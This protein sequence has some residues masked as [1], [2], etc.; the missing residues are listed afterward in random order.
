MP[1]RSKRKTSAPEH[2]FG[3]IEKQIKSVK[4]VVVGTNVVLYGRSATGKTTLACTWPKPLLLIDINETGT[5]SVQDVEGVS[6]M[7]CRTWEELDQTYWYLRKKGIKKFK[8]VVVDTMSKAQR[9]AIQSHLGME[10]GNRKVGE[11]GEMTKRDWGRVSSMVTELIL[12]FHDLPVNTVFIAH[13]RVFNVDD[14]EDQL[15]PEVGP[16]LMPSVASEINAAVGVIGN[17][18]I[19]EKEIKLKKGKKTITRTKIEYCLRIGPNSVYTTKVRKPRGV[20]LPDV[21]VDP[22]YENIMN[23]KRGTNGSQS[24]ESKG[25]LQRRR[26]TSADQGGT[27]PDQ[28]RRNLKRKRASR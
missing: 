25:K 6:V 12:D 5:D 19:R 8:T 26:N 27:V 4:D 11:W 1:Q 17:T 28:T 16:R 14:D 2:D 23:L 21:L 15:T 20:R 7:Q 3:D 13:D 18:F 9:M 24:S 22:T 10:P